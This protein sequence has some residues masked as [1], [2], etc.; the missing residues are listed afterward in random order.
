M[1]VDL[2]LESLLTGVLNEP[3]L[4]KKEL[5]S[6]LRSCRTTAE[7]WK[8]PEGAQKRRRK[9]RQVTLTRRG[10]FLKLN[11]YSQEIYI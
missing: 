4:A 7:L 1:K 5:Q 11:D 8:G 6:N 10:E 3:I 2:V 9:A